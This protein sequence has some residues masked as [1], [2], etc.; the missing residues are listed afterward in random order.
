MLDLS[1]M[2][3][4]SMI[5][6]DA[7]LFSAQA[8]AV[9]GD[10][11]TALGPHDLVLTSGNFGDTGVGGLA[12]AGGVGYLARSQGLTL[13]HLVRARLVLA[14]GSIRWVNAENEPDLFWAIRGGATQV[15]VATDLVFRAERIGSEHADASVI[16]QEAAY[17]TDSLGDFVRGW[18]DWI[19]QA[20]RELTSF[21]SLYRVE[22]GRFVVQAKN[23]WAGTDVSGA[24]PVLQGAAD[25][26]PLLNHQAF[27]TP[28]PSVVPTPRSPHLGQ[29][30]IKMRDVLVDRVDAELGEAIEESL[31]HP[32]TAVAEL[33]SL[34]GA[35]A[36]VPAGATAWAGRHQEG[37]VATWLHPGGIEVQD[38]SFAALQRLGTG[39][40]GAYSSDTRPAFAELTWPGET[41]ERLG[42]LARR[43]DPDWLFDNGLVLPR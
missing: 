8:G 7:G 33:R 3:Q 19:R 25:L 38:A 27:L 36:D 28:Y 2:R 17:Q 4:I 16:W 5:D 21:L 39:A 22:A 23:M 1:A 20:P 31:A 18:G 40:Y 41:G 24:E 34:G 37:L 12:T 11:A 43:V 35:V 30:R 6:P 42:S 29:Q 26:A 9:W 14:D 10:V 32:S 13:D 15:G